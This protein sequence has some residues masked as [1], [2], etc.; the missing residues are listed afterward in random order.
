M[1]EIVI[2]RPPSVNRLWRM[3]NGRM[4]RSAEYVGWLNKCMVLAK[5]KKFPSILGKYK[6]MIRVA[7]PDKRRRDIDNI[8]KAASDFLQHA[9]IVQ[10]D[11]LCE[12]LYCKWVESGP[13]VTINIYPVGAG[14][15]ISGRAKRTVQTGAEKHGKERDPRSPRDQLAAAYTE[16]RARGSS[17]K[18]RID[19]R[20]V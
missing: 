3:G 8:V 6:L 18:A 9:G 14:N 5:E 12:T 17:K 20:K 16:A 7:R 19:F 2:P 15:V 11:C 10:D 1:V 13:E 4:Y